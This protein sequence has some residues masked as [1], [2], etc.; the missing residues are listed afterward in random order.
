MNPM[1]GTRAWRAGVKGH[2]RITKIN[3][4]STLNMGLNEAV[5]HLR[6]QPGTKVNV[7]IHRDGTDGWPG[8][9]PFELMREVIHVWSVDH[10]LLD[11]GIGYVRIRQ[12][13][14]NTATDLQAALADM[15][16]GGEL[17]GVVLDLRGNPGGLLDQAAKVVHTFLNDSPI[18]SPAGH[19]THTRHT[20][21]ARS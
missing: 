16:R 9:K 7:W 11:G 13:Q 3:N 12:F 21:S 17:K 1:P 2:D 19:P 6:G 15:K 18:V 14:A 10:K 4:E 8:A 5:N 20:T